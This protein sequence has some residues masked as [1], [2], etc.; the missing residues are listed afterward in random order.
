M[1][2]IDVPVNED[3][4]GTRSVLNSLIQHDCTYVNH[5]PADVTGCNHH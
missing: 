5:V 1:R 4:A 3:L 2:S